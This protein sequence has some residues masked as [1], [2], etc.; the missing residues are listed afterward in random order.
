[1][2]LKLTR[3]STNCGLKYYPP[4]ADLK[5]AMGNL[6]LKDEAES[7]LQRQ[8]A[9]DLNAFGMRPA[10]RD[11]NEF[12]LQHPD[13]QGQTANRGIER[14]DTRNAVLDSENLQRLDEAED[15]LKMSLPTENALPIIDWHSGPTPMDAW[16]NQS[17]IRMDGGIVKEIDDEQLQSME[18]LGQ[19]ERDIEILRKVHLAA[20]PAAPEVGRLEDEVYDGLDESAKPFL[21]K[22][23][24]K[25]PLIQPF[26]ARRLAESSMSRD[27]RLRQSR[28]EAERKRRSSSMPWKPAPLGHRSAD[29]DDYDR[30][31][32]TTFLDG[33]IRISPVESPLPISYR[34]KWER[35]RER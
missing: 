1:M 19:E 9:E 28:D 5:D 13:L 14:T 34:Q 15:D 6:Q 33:T 16:L 23:L 3:N 22:I 8:A 2:L 32:Q 12:G 24:D 7:V 17:A 27:I 20:E 25:F 18:H 31:D 29:E 11:A 30:R 35:E 21:R 4:I 10:P 26:L